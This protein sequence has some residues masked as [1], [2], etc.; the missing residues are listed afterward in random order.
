MISNNNNFIRV[1]ADLHMHGLYSSAVSKQMIP[2]VIAQQ[3]PRKGLHLVGTADILHSKWQQL[4]KEQLKPTDQEAIFAHENKT[5]F[6]LQTEVE[7]N[8][9]VHHLIFFPSMS[10]VQEVKEAFQNKS[11][12]LDSDGRPNILLNGAEITQ[13]CLDAGCL[14]GPA[15]GFTPYFGIYG[16]FNSYKECYGDLWRKINF[17][18]LGLSADTKMADRISELHNLTFLSNSDCHSPWPN[19]L[20]REFNTFLMQEISFNE[21]EK[22][23]RREQGRKSVLNVGLNPLEG[24]YHK[25]RCRGCL[26]FFEP[27]DALTLNWRCPSCKNFIKKG[28]DYRISELASLES[29]VHP[30]HRPEYKHII[31]LS[32]I[33][34]LAIG[35][36]DSW[37]VKVQNEWK[38]FVSRFGNEVRVLL[39]SQYEKME[40]LNPKVAEFVQHFREGKIKYVPG[41]GGVYG[42]LVPPGETLEIKEFKEK[43]KTLGDF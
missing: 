28:V 16:K 32:E 7:D 33:I 1:N 27:K 2:R 23:F 25:T 13:I 39:Y 34:A 36:K 30:D 9:R 42:K 20:G 40:E 22:V 29:G 15:H 24:R 4:I 5:K 10:K 3:A 19:K 31:P 26:T 12:N 38:R 11:K 14:I 6:I 17:L 8:N 43:Q 18:E 41:G 37:S 35:I 21:L